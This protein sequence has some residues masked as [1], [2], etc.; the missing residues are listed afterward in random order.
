MLHRLALVSTA[1]LLALASATALGAADAALEVL[2]PSTSGPAEARKPERARWSWNQAAAEVTATGDL[3]WKPAAFKLEVGKTVRYIDFEKGSDDADGSKDKP[4]KHHPWDAAA[5][6]KAKAQS[7][8]TTYVFKRGVVYRGALVTRESGAAGD[9]I[10]LTS[11]P[12]WGKGEA[13]IAGSEIVT[14]WKK[15]SDN[16]AMPDAGA[17]WY[18][19][20][21]FAPRNVWEVHGDQIERVELARTPNWKVSDPEEV[22]GEWW[23]WEQPEWWTGKHKIDF[24]GHRVHRGVDAKHLTQ[25][26][27]YYVGANVRTGYS[28]VMGTPYPTRVE[29]YDAQNKALMFQGIWFGD[30]GDLWTNN[31]Y[32]LE[33]KPQYLDAPGEFWFDKK[34]DGG[35]LYLRLAGDRDPNASSIEA[36]KRFDLIEDAASAG[37]PDRMD[38][39]NAQQREQLELKGIAH[40]A[41]TVLTFRFTNTPWDLTLP[42]WGG[43]EIDNACIRLQGSTDD[44]RIANCRFEHAGKAVKVI[45]LDGRCRNGSVAVTDCDVLRMDTG[46]F[47]I[48]NGGN[49][50]IQVARNRMSHIG[51]RPYRQSNGHAVEIG[52]PETMDISGNILERCYGS[53]LF[54]W[55][56]KGGGDTRD[57]AL[58]RNLIHHNRVV[59]SLLAA[60]DWGG[61]ETW[62]GGPFYVYSNISGNPNGR[63]QAYDPN[64]EGTARLG[65]AYYHDGGFDNYDFNNVA[66]GRSSDPK[67]ILCNQA[68]FYE[69]VFTTENLF[70]NNTISKFFVGTAWSPG[71]GR[72]F[73]LG[74]LMID[75]PGMAFQ[76]GKLKEDKG[77]KPAAYPHETMAYGHNVFGGVQPKTFSVFESKGTGHDVASMGK[78]LAGYGALASDV[79]I[80][81]DQPLVKDNDQHDFRPVAGSAAIDRGVKVFV[82]WGL[83]RT[84]GEWHFRPSS[85]DYTRVLD[86]HWHMAAYY[87]NRDMYHAAPKFDLKANAATAASYV[88]GPLED[89]TDGAFAF[90]G[91][92]SFL[93]SAHAEMVK[94]FAYKA[95]NQDKQAAGKEIV[96]P[97]IDTGSL[98]IETYVQAKAGQPASVLVAKMAGSGYQLA[99]NKAGGV[100]LTLRSGDAKS[101]VASGARIAD[102][103]WHHVLAELDRQAGTLAIYT[104]G[105]KTA[106]A[107][108]TLPVDA[109]L[110]ND[111]DLLVGKGAQGGFFAGA[112]DFL[113]IARSSL[114][115]SKTS[116]E[117]LYDWELDGPFLRDFAGR[118]IVG[119]A[120]DAG[121]FEADGK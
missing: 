17:I 93:S 118:E 105:K 113:R 51:A 13:V 107:K 54:V 109:S 4:W 53:G 84:V 7:G 67:S 62:Q 44:V 72:H 55:G 14:G 60:N 97:D 43:K 85:A 115:E 86:N 3:A 114:A 33:D 26:A 104:D 12:A 5:A 48:D 21:A 39:L 69:A 10:R 11:D 20:V 27:D 47:A 35:R 38:I 9:P 57:V 32:Y 71:G 56:G 102:G 45:R 68:A 37:Q 117:E 92:S 80:V 46:A 100:T 121:A 59:D 36:A 99:L 34:G 23:A 87:W 30:S 15:G 77:E 96:S 66:W 95:G 91:S 52:Y 120:R 6:G 29:G 70:F 24:Q 31:K 74:N 119:K 2:E 89:W 58:S 22:Q 64:K 41:I 103:K 110:A 61:I 112:M 90:D 1:S 111:S 82:P 16:A 73:F 83:S 94:P 101:E 78:A 19:D 108:S 79:G 8:P 63:W 18:A 76:H 98:V 28:V 81:S 42:G 50:H 40:V 25:P 49:G 106:E 116:I 75:L 88:A 65:F